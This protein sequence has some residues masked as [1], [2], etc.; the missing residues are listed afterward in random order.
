VRARNWLFQFAEKWSIAETYL[1]LGSFPGAKENAVEI[2][3]TQ[4]KIGWSQA[5]DE[6][7]SNEFALLA[8]GRDEGETAVVHLIGT[9]PTGWGYTTEIIDG[10]GEWLESVRPQ[11]LSSTLDAIVAHI[12]D[13]M[14]ARS[15]EFRSLKLLRKER[16]DDDQFRWVMGDPTEVG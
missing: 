11:S 6:L 14:A 8:P 5:L 13:G 2:H 12:L 9:R 15:S 16:L 7:T 4:I 3:N 10:S 1:G